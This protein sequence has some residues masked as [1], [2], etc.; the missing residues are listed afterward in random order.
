MSRG[1]KSFLRSSGI[2]IMIY[3]TEI[4]V[5]L[6]LIGQVML[7]FNT[8]DDFS[9]DDRQLFFRCGPS[10][11]LRSVMSVGHDKRKLSV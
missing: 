4:V 11:Q 2:N 5:T 6:L 9:L 8:D 3:E 7:L 1:T 10:V